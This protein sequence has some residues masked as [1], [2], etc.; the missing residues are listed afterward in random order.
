MT[1]EFRCSCGAICQADESQV[2][3]LIQCASCGLDVPVPSPHAAMRVIEDDEAGSEPETAAAPSDAAETDSPDA[4]DEAPDAETA[5]TSATDALREQLGAGGGVADIAAHIHDGEGDTAVAE[6]AAEAEK[7]R[8]DADALR[9]QLGGDAE[10]TAEKRRG[11]ADALREQL[12]GGGIAD[13]ADALREDG[14]AATPDGAGAPAA[15]AGAGDLPAAARQRL[16][17]PKKKVL[18][19]H[20]RAAHHIAFKKAIWLP[21]LLVGLVCLAVGICAGVF[22]VHPL[23]IGDLISG[24]EDPYAEHVARFHEKLKKAGI[25]VDGYDIVE[26]GGES[27]AIPKGADHRKSSGG[28]VYYSVASGFEEEAVKAQK[29]AESMAIEQ[30]SQSGLLKFGI[31]L[32]LVGLALFVLSMITLRDVRMVRAAQAPP[33]EEEPET[34]EPADEA[35]VAAEADSEP[36]EAPS[37]EAAEGEGEETGGEPPEDDDAADE[38]AEGGQ[39]EEDADAGDDTSIGDD[40]AIGEDTSVDDADS[41]GSDDAGAGEADEDETAPAGGG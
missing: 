22:R 40:T 39:G 6:A 15:A 31:A 20:E 26:H 24:K 5:S 8:Q 7:H 35:P 10:A 2:G 37:G 33:P 16:T 13:I 21:S 12:G 17:A 41:A 29:Y 1:I 4:R 3:Q 36:G 27:W 32:V 25:P 18:R 19:G 38:K 9:E 30:R 23:E 34:P 11:D 14:D 28:R